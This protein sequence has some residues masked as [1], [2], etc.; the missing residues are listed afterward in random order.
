MLKLQYLGHLMRRTAS[1]QKTL[2]LGN[3]EGG[4]RRGRQRMRWLDSIINSMEMSLSQLRELMVD[5][6][7]WCAA[8]HGVTKSWHDWVTER[9]W[10]DISMDRAEEPVWGWIKHIT[11]IVHFVSVYYYISSTS[12][13]QP[14]DPRGRGPM[15]FQ[16]TH[17]ISRCCKCPIFTFLE[18]H[19]HSQLKRTQVFTW[20]TKPWS[21][22]IHN[23]IM[24]H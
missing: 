22:V 11:F 13:H 7:A 8:V 4:R 19:F 12:D 15:N 3:I 20:E 9:N 16:T 2:M 17:Q 24:D 18:W 21:F 23:T 1:L 5:R 6:E 14:L 10:T